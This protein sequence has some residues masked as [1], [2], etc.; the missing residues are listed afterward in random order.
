MSTIR[1]GIAGH[2]YISRE[3]VFDER[4]IA[5]CHLT[6]EE[7]IKA[8]IYKHKTSEHPGLP[9]EAVKHMMDGRWK[10]PKPATRM[11]ERELITLPFATAI[12]VRARLDRQ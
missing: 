10:D 8:A 1:T 7:A 3:V 4:E 11:T 2:P 12:D 6:Q 5:A 9:H